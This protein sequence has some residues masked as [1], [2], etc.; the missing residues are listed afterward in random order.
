MVVA[1]LM[2]STGALALSTTVTQSG[3]DSDEV[4]KDSTFIVEASGWTGDC[5]QAT[6]SFSG[7]SSCSLSGEDQIKTIGGGA[8]SIT[9]TTVSASNTASAQTVNVM[10]GSGCTTQNADSSSFDIVLPPSLA[11]TASSGTSSIAASGTFTTN[12][13]VVNNGGTTAQSI[14]IS[15][16]SPFS[17]SC[18]TISTLDE[19]Q[20]AAQSCTV[21]AASTAGSYVVTFTAASTNADDATDT[22]SVTVTGGGGDDGN[23]GGG[24][25]GTGVSSDDIT[26]I[27]TIGTIDAGATGT[28]TF[29]NNQLAL[30]EVAITAKDAVSSVVIDTLQSAT[31]P[32]SVSIPTGSI[33]GYLTINALNIMEDNITTATIKFRVNQSWLTARGLVKE[34]IVL[35][36]FTDNAWVDLP[37]SVV[38]TDADYVHFSS[39]TPGFSIFVIATRSTLDQ[40]DDGED[41]QTICTAGDKRCEGDKLQ[42]CSSNGMVWGDLE[43]CQFGCNAATLECN[44]ESEAPTAPAPIPMEWIIIIVVVI[45]IIII[46]ILVFRRSTSQ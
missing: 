39:I 18:S 14:A 35:R 6:I 11:L 44:T 45:V 15:A 9:W 26:E 25:G 37:T 12:L 34:D 28:A 16:G 8:T 23:G 27:I 4:M 29:T 17:S 21:T 13:N 33:Y 7:C 22:I 24:G 43:T 36:R 20:S 3:A 2:L 32:S 40:P 5:S 1:S 46:G 42:Q 30:T 41:Q 19:G 31:R 38:S 10:V